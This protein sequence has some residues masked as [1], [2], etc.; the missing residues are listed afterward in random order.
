LIANV[1]DARRGR[2]LLTVP[3]VQ[4]AAAIAALV[5]RQRDLG[6]ESHNFPQIRAIQASTKSIS[7]LGLERQ[8]SNVHVC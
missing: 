5:V 2:D 4:T 6:A 8:S 3:F 1:G 7:K